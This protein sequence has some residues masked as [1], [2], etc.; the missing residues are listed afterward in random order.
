MRSWSLTD[1]GWDLSQRP[2]IDSLFHLDQRGRVTNKED[3]VV[4]TITWSTHVDRF[5][6]EEVRED[7]SYEAFGLSRRYPIQTFGATYQVPAASS[8]MSGSCR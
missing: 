1:A 7:I 3:E 8:A 4:S 2:T 6:R 5:A